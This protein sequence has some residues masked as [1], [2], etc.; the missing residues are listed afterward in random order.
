ML[1]VLSENPTV[2]FYLRMG[3]EVD[4][5]IQADFGGQ[6]LDELVMRFELL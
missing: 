3:G 4:R 1:T 6:Q 5:K 2:E